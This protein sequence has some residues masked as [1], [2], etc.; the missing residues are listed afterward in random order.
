MSANWV[1][2]ARFSGN[3]NSVIS[4]VSKHLPLLLFSYWHSETSA[5][6]S[7]VI[8]TNDHFSSPPNAPH[9]CVCSSQPTEAN[10]LSLAAIAMFFHNAEFWNTQL[11]NPK[12]KPSLRS[13]TYPSPINT[14]S[15]SRS[16]GLDTEYKDLRYN[17]LCSSLSY[18]ACK[19]AWSKVRCLN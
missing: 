2:R 13:Q 7:A 18:Q 14:V 19:K 4:T 9:P 17:L 16:E 11:V 1:N 8:R 5:F 6:L 15:T 12:C 3:W 10:G